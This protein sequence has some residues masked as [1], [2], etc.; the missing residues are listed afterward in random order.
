MMLLCSSKNTV[1]DF[2]ARHIRDHANDRTVFV[3][4][5]CLSGDT[6]IPLLNGTIKTL[7][8]LSELYPNGEQ[9]YV[10]SLDTETNRIVPG[11]AHHPRLTHKNEK[12]L[13]ITLD[14]GS[15]IVCTPD[16]RFLLRD[17]TYIQA[18]DLRQHHEL[19]PCNGNTG[20]TARNY[21]ANTEQHA[22]QDVYDL[23]VDKYNNFAIDAGVFVHNS[24]WD[25]LPEIYKDSPK[26]YVLCG[27]EYVSSKI[28]EPEELDRYTK[29]LPDAT[30]IIEVPEDFRT[31]FQ[32]NI[33]MAIRDLGGQST[34]SVSPFIQQRDKI[35]EA[36]DPKLRPH[37]LKDLEHPFTKEVWDPSTPGEFIWER[38]MSSVS[39]RLYD[40]SQF[41]SMRPKINP[42]ASRHIHYDPSLTQDCTGVCFLAGTKI[43]MADLKQKNIEDVIVGDRII[44]AYGKV[45]VVTTT[46]KN[47]YTGK[48]LNINR[49]GGSQLQVTP[50]HPIL[51]SKYNYVRA[52]LKSKS[53]VLGKKRTKK[54]IE[55]H[56]Q[57]VTPEFNSSKS[58]KRKDY[59]ASPC[60]NFDDP[61]WD[62]TKYMFS[63]NGLFNITPELGTIIGYYLAEGSLFRQ[64]NEKTKLFP[65]FT[66]GWNG[67]DE[68]HIDKLKKAITAVLSHRDSGSLYEIKYKYK[69]ENSSRTVRIL[70]RDLGAFLKMYCGEYSAEK[71]IHPFL[72]YGTTREFRDNLLT[73]YWEGDGTINSFRRHQDDGKLRERSWS[74]FVKTASP[75]I[76]S[77]MEI[78]CRSKGASI[79]KGYETFEYTVGKRNRQQPIY[80]LSINGYYQ[81]L[82]VFSRDTLELYGEPPKHADTV[83]GFSFMQHALYPIRE[84]TEIDYSGFVYNLEVT[85]SHT[86]VANDISVHNCMA[87]IAGYKDVQRRAEDGSLYTE[88]APIF[89]VD[90][91]LRIVPPVGGEIE[92]GLVRRLIYE[93]AQHGYSI[94]KITADTHQS[95]D[96]LQQ[97]QQKGFSTDILSVDLTPDA[98]NHL[99]TALYENRVFMYEYKPIIEELQQIE[100]KVEGRRIKIDHP[101][102]GK[103]D[104]SDAL[105]GCLYS[106]S[107]RTNTAPMPIM[108]TGDGA[109]DPWLNEHIQSSY[110]AR[111][112]K[113]N[114][115]QNQRYQQNDIP[116]IIGGF[117]GEAPDD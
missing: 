50:D 79:R 113:S 114:R 93:L 85:G 43:L 40:G 112:A 57:N 52:Y 105:A 56:I 75:H 86:Y 103:K 90:F 68:R 48:I 19:M 38:M 47:N 92:L 22:A 101:P 70:D 77:A 51:S 74:V 14:S 83:R 94:T 8:E 23:S 18:Q 71:F 66:F 100:R 21:V 107:Q 33:E 3:R 95:R 106:L 17:G 97:L 16:H 59:V 39:E 27:N 29:N 35:I 96:G 12:V 89:G 61:E 54:T 1:D 82:R 49:T 6:K 28:I 25:V 110:A 32:S 55:N 53:G 88:R 64:K 65:Q 5:R 116:M 42:F 45:Q 98:Y 58:L 26:F 80:R 60:I 91:M 36:T 7:K 15:E 41:T 78:L 73:A 72:L 44:D 62:N 67:L 13:K 11:I 102:S 76:A 2:L 81:L 31:D 69:G 24:A 84:I 99:K 117:S 30:V 9:F 34:I 37:N 4:D 104:I 46:F 87:H 10:Y 115:Q 108:L 63:N 109:D 20:T 111:F